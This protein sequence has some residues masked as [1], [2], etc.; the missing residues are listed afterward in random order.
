MLRRMLTLIISILSIIFIPYCLSLF[1]NMYWWTPE[2]PGDVKPTS[3]I[4]LWMQ[5]F[6]LSFLLLFVFLII[7]TIKWIKT[8]K[9]EI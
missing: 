2:Y 3:F 4:T 7:S 9:F 6:D 5:G 8:G 1:Y